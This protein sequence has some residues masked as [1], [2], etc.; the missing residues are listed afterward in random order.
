MSDHSSGPSAGSR[1]QAPRDPARPAPPV[2]AVDDEPLVARLR[3]LTLVDLDVLLG[4]ATPEQVAAL[5]D[6]HAE[7]LADALRAARARMHALLREVA[8]GPDPFGL[9]DAD[10]RQRTREN[11]RAAGERSARR[12]RVRAQACRA[13]ARLDEL[14]AHILPRLLEA[15]R[16]RHGHL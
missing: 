12:L 16:R 13:L 14:A 4:G 1:A 15:D 3:D 9:L 10:A 6:A 2:P 7:D 8:A 11:A 5:L